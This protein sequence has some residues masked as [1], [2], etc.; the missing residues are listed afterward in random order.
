MFHSAT[1]TWGP[2]IPLEPHPNVTAATPLH[3][4]HH[5]SDF[6]STS[7]W[8]CHNTTAYSI[9][10]L[11]RANGHVHVHSL[12]PGAQVRFINM[13]V[14]AAAGPGTGM[15]QDPAKASTKPGSNTKRLS[16]G[17]AAKPKPLPNPSG[18]RF[19]CPKCPKTFSRIENLT[20]HQAN[21]ESKSM[22]AAAQLRTKK[23]A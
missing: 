12:L 22:L 17:D 10:D 1:L 21:R 20:R 4:P 23:Q 15:Q 7:T 5:E 9:D 16:K 11:D 2:S 8:A 13:D 14:A 18:S 19:Q 3:S 6:Y